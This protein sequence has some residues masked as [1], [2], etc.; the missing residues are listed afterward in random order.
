MVRMVKKEGKIAPEKSAP[1][2]PFECGG[3]CNC[4]LGNAHMEVVT[5][6]KVLPLV[7]NNFSQMCTTEPMLYCSIYVIADMHKH[8]QLHICRDNCEGYCKYSL[9]ITRNRNGPN[10]PRKLHTHK[11]EVTLRY[12]TKNMWIEKEISEGCGSQIQRANMNKDRLMNK[13][14]K[15]RY[16][17]QIM[18]IP[19][20]L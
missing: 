13:T 15:Y 20:L 8:T 4:Y 3:G 9:T 1:E 6:W 5:S 19:L 17:K 16:V 10:N 7:S 14:Q 11:L 18:S 12:R 2:C